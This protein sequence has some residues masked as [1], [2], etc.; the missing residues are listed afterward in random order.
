MHVLLIEDNKPV[1]DMIKLL[2]SGKGFNIAAAECGEDG[3]DLAR[4][5]NYDII[6]LDLQLPDISGLQVLRTL[7]SSAIE[8]PVLVLSG[9]MVVDARVKALG[10]GAD[11]FL[12]KP[13]HKDELIARIHAVVRRSQGHSQTVITTGK[14][15][16]NLDSRT[17]EAKGVRVP[18]TAREYQILE[19]LSLRKG[20]TLSKDLLMDHLYGGMDEPEAKI[21]DVFICK[22]RKKLA[23]V[24]DGEQYIQ[25]VWGSGYRLDDMAMRTAA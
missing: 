3:I 21:I 20:A 4:R 2:L 11:D 15:N 12:T 23:S 6:I 5:Y 19:L 10:I 18:V 8:T 9:N 16:V 1:A 25:T 17:V 24:C 13:F 14:L 7:R 22:L